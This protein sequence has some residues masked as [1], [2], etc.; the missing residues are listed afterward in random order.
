MALRV[1]WGGVGRLGAGDGLR[2]SDWEFWWAILA[3]RHARFAV[4]FIR[5]LCPVRGRQTVE[6]ET[7]IGGNRDQNI[8]HFPFYPAGFAGNIELGS[9]D[10][11]YSALS[12]IS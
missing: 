2:V 9:I 3:G 11:D 5:Q 8:P 4:G 7:K 10:R 12:D 1:A 6:S